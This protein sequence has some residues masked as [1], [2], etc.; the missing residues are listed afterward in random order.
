ECLRSDFLRRRWRWST[1]LS[2]TLLLELRLLRAL[3]HPEFERAAS[4][5]RLDLEP[6]PV[7]AE[8]MRIVGAK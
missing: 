1:L 8:A 3:E 7:Y 6:F 2:D 5:A 4:N